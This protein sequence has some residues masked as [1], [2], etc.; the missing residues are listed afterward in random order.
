[1]QVQSA[2]RNRL[3]STQIVYHTLAAAILFLFAAFMDRKPVWSLQP[4]AA[5]LLLFTALAYWLAA[6][7]SIA[8]QRR[9]RGISRAERLAI[10]FAAAAAVFAAGAFL[11]S[12]LS[13]TLTLWVPLLGLSL[14]LFGQYVHSRLTWRLL[15]VPAALASAVIATMWVA[16]EWLR[17]HI[18]AK[19]APAVSHF[20]IRSSLYDLAVTSF[21][22]YLPAS[23]LPRG[24]LA[25]LADR[26]LLATGDGQFYTFRPS[27]DMQSLEVTRL[28]YEVPVNAAA[29]VKASNNQFRRDAFRTGDIIVQQKSGLL[30][31]FAT[32]RYW[33]S[34]E[35]CWVM[36]VSS[37]QG[38]PEQ[39]L[40]DRPTLT[41]K[42]VFETSPCIPLSLPGQ[43]PRFSPLESGGRLAWSA[44]G[45][46]L[47][48]FGDH[49]MD[50]WNSVIQAPQ[51][52]AYSFGKIISID[53][54]SGSSE[55]FSLGHR[56]PQGLD[57]SSTAQVWATEHGP[58]GGDELNLITKGGNYGW[59]FATYGTQY[60]A[61]NWPLVD[62]AGMNRG[63]VEPF[64]SWVPSIGVS[65]LIE[66][67]SPSF[68]RW[69]G[70]LLACSLRDMAFW[71]LRIREGRVVMTERFLF[72]QR[73]RDVVQGHD[74][75][76]VVW[77]DDRSISFIAPAAKGDVVAGSSIF[78]LC[79]QCHIAP[80]EGV[81][82]VGPSLVGI[83][84]R[85]VASDPDFPVF[86]GFA[87][88]GGQVDEIG[89]MR[90]SP[91]RT[92]SRR[93]R[94]CHPSPCTT[95]QAARP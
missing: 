87:P 32:R 2:S 16:P 95:L 65:C 62:E 74:G 55:L 91:M 22:N 73:I 78:R 40:A 47:V 50:G 11:D 81:P 4:R 58:E 93:A 90:F 6:M 83:V 35:R 31:V 52:A 75:T 30:R 36:R 57:V 76:L 42:T 38:T 49:A 5:F 64:Y 29:F 43:P 46:L 68:E 24:G 63:F 41:W 13:R 48:T 67:T 33:K 19:P 79:G 23:A 26:Y 56:N 77:S 60:G 94:R 34:A 27:P 84:D 59:P 80:A 1:M 7:G 9:A 8:L 54:E 20:R 21:T 92:A 69:R 61:Y 37:L 12:G 45:R 51:D 66:V 70:D 44:E 89:S 15:A 18:L 39:F 14:L 85:P 10:S 82:A 86:A 72:G 88:I 28:A 71:R 3:A 25:V 17:S 53:P